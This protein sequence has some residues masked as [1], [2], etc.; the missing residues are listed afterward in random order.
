MRQEI[1]IKVVRKKKRIVV[2]SLW[3]DLLQKT[4]YLNMQ[5]SN[6]SKAMEAILH[7]KYRS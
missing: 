6:K 2:I 4:K 5:L 7:S 1:Q 3:G